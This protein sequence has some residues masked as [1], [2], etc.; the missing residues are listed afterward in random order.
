VKERLNVDAPE[1][2]Y[3]L[4]FVWLPSFIDCRAPA[5]VG[6]VVLLVGGRNPMAN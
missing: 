5:I 4:V 2:F 1:N 6:R 3:D